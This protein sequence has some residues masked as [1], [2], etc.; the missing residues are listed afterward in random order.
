MMNGAYNVKT[1]STMW[2]PVICLN[3]TIISEQ[4]A[5]VSSIIFSE[6]GGTK[7]LQFFW[8]K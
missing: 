3:V 4:T 8:P 6:D 2:R 5:A 7:F 1:Y